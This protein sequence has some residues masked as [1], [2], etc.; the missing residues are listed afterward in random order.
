MTA[1]NI[2]FKVITVIVWIIFVGLSIEACGLLVNFIVSL[3]NPD[4]TNN[5]YNKL[6]LMQMYENSR[7][8]Y[9]R[10]YSFILVIAF[11]KAVLFLVIIYLMHKIDLKKP[12][13]AF[14]AKQISTMSYI[15]L[16][17]GL[18]SYIYLKWSEELRILYP[19]LQA[20]SDDSQAYVFMGCVLYIIA[21]IFKRGVELQTEND[22]TI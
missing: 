15:T 11:L 5:L 8:D 9:I 21:T 4:I 2:I 16:S 12:F 18:L 7:L 14:V 10:T 3:L 17:V 20:Y 1:H 22:L 19:E 13:S 6:N